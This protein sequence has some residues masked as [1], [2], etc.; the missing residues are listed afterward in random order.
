MI[1]F[2]FP[3]GTTYAA[4]K[5]MPTH[6]KFDWGGTSDVLDYVEG[7]KEPSLDEIFEE[8]EEPKT[9]DTAAEDEVYEEKEETVEEKKEDPPWEEP[10]KPEAPAV[11]PS[12]DNTKASIRIL[13]VTPDG[14][15]K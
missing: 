8:E 15:M 12:G 9:P 7:V 5:S 1:T 2:M 3:D 10:K 4:I 11:V 13:G 14:T 6:K